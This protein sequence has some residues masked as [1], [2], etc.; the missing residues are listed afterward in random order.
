MSFDL[1]HE[2]FT[3]VTP[4]PAMD[5][6]HY[7]EQLTEVGGRLAVAV[8][9]DRRNTII[10]KVWILKGPGDKQ[11][12][13]H[14]RTIQGLQPSQKMEHAYFAYDKCVLTSIYQQVLGKT[15]FNIVYKH[16]SCSLQDDS[17][18]IRAIAGTPVAKFD[19]RDLRMFSYTETTETLDIYNKAYG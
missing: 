3:P 16:L 14:W 8:E 6:G 5:E 15:F 17:I 10:V 11:R 13:S 12:W 19:T 1:E 18:L 2:C 9:I 7:C 4:L